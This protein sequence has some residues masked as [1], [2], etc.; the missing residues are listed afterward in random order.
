MIL[1][2]NWKKKKLKLQVFI[3]IKPEQ[4][5]SNLGVLRP[6]TQPE[7]NAAKNKHVYHA[8]GLAQTLNSSYHCRT[9][10]I[11]F[12]RCT[13]NCKR[14]NPHTTHVLPHYHSLHRRPFFSS[15]WSIPSS[16]KSWCELTH[17]HVMTTVFSPSHTGLSDIMRAWVLMSWGDNCG[18]SFGCVWI[19]PRGSISWKQ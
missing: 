9:L 1:G 11:F 7:Q 17:L 16:Q 10:H 15:H 6:V 14:S 13:E 4:Q 12:F 18:N 3:Q 8:H 2:W 19:R 5:A